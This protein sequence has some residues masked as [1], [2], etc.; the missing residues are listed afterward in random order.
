MSRF[1]LK[2]I[3]VL[4]LAES[5]GKNKQNKN[6]MCPMIHNPWSFFEAVPLNGEQTTP[7]RDGGLF[8]CQIEMGVS[9]V[10]NNV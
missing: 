6:H 8:A 4:R 5:I 1:F 7:C 9:P 2:R 10:V 3:N